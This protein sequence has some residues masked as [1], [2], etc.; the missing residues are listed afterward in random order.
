MIYVKPKKNYP[1]TSHYQGM[2]EFHRVGVAK[3]IPG[4]DVASLSSTSFIN[5][6]YPV[7]FLA[8]SLLVT[9]LLHMQ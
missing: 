3:Q 8:H 7:S 4:S 9:D 1:P 6:S 5:V 2:I